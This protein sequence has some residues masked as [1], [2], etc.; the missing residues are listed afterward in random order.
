VTPFD[1]DVQTRRIFCDKHSVEQRKLCR[2]EY[3]QSLLAAAM[4]GS[5][6]AAPDTASSAGGGSS[7]SSSA[8]ASGGA[9]ASSSEGKAGKKKSRKSLAPE[10]TPLHV[11]ISGCLGEKTTNLFFDPFFRFLLYCFLS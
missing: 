1:P 8:T 10:I 7:S 9:A 2:A 5:A 6:G 4:G 11:C 3:E